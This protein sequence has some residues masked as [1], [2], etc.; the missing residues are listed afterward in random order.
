MKKPSKYAR[1]PETP[2]ES[3]RWL[4]LLLVFLS[5]AAGLIYQ[6]LWMKQIGMLFG[7]T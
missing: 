4:I 5:G 2:R 1:K 7:N 6:V 3:G